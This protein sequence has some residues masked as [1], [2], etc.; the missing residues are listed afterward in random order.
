M[1]I[2]ERKIVKKDG[3]ITRSRTILINVDTGERYANGRKKYKQV[4]RTVGRSSQVTKKEARDRLD[5]EEDNFKKGRSSILNLKSP[6]LSEFA[7]DYTSYVRDVVGKR[8]WKSD[9]NSLKNLCESFGS[10]TLDRI[11]PLILHEYQKKRLNDGRR[12]STVNRE[13]A[14]LRYLY[15]VAKVRGVY[16]G[17]NPVQSVRFLEENNQIERVLSY[18]EEEKLLRYAASHMVPIII[19]ALNTGMR[20]GEIITLR[21]DNVD[22]KKNEITVESTY[23]KTKKL[24]RIPINSYLR[25]ILV[26]LNQDI[27]AYVFLTPQGEH[28]KGQN[29]IKTSFTR[30]CKQAGVPG[31]RFHDLRHTAATRML[32]KGAKLEEVA[33]ILGHYDIRT[34]MRYAHPDDSLRTAAEYLTPPRHNKVITIDDSG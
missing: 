15:N 16:V 9:V 33:K 23:T 8:S 19:C 12:P 26:E 2:G 13:L 5:I 21:W 6:M 7:K 11:S 22:F 20:K 4:V 34:T 31:L 10:I 24:R 3:K 30:A 28:Y 29:S 18:E 1:G 14:C 17:N 32:E 27:S 25:E